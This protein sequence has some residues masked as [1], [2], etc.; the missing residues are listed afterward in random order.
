MK[1]MQLSE[2]PNFIQKAIEKGE[3][4]EMIVRSGRK[5]TTRLTFRIEPASKDEVRIPC[6]LVPKS[7]F[8]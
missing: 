7:P 3:S 1:T 6:L 2:L 5:V 8:H 4:V